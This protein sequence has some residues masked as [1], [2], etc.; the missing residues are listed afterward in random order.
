MDV[1][2]PTSI[3][4]LYRYREREGEVHST[5]DISKELSDLVIYTR[6]RNLL[7]IL[8]KLPDHW[9]PLHHPDRSD[10]LPYRLGAYCRIATTPCISVSLCLWP[11]VTLWSSPRT[12]LV[13]TW[14][15]LLDR[16]H[17]YWRQMSYFTTFC[18]LIQFDDSIK[19]T[20]A[21]EMYGR[22]TFDS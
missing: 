18:F 10:W 5:N 16:I 2:L 4:T 19:Y 15:R 20:S 11:R 1:R 22:L 6:Y 17:R 14:I 7:Y 8:S 3:S 21:A 12:M 9:L 13:A